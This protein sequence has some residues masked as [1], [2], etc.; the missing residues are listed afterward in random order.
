M[1]VTASAVSAFT[2]F[3]LALANFDLYRGTD[4]TA[5]P[6]DNPEPALDVWQVFDGEPDCDDASSAQTWDDSDD[7]SGDKFGVVYEPRP[8]DP[9]DPGAATRVEMNFH[10]TDPVYHFT[11]YK[12]RNYD[13]I[14]LDGNTYGNCVPFPGDDYQ[15]NYPLPLGDRVLSGARFFRCTTDLTA[16]QIN[17]V[18]GKKR[19]VKI[20]VKF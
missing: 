4:V 1:K 9:S 2:L 17:E 3:H 14:G 20:A 6:D 16:Q 5:V 18:N 19:S 7:V 13:M 8:A 12:D 15:C 10:D 11:I